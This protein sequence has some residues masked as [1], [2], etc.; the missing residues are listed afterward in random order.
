MDAA[1]IRKLADLEDQHW[2]Y[3]ERRAVL[4]RALDSLARAGTKPGR[5]LDIGAAGGGNTR[6]LRSRGW[7]AT[8]LEYGAEGAA[9]AHGRNIPVIRGD[10]VRLPLGDET[11]DLVV[12]YDVLEHIEDDKAASDEIARVLRPGGVALIAVPVDMALWSEHDV[13][14]GHVRRYDRERLLTVLTSAGLAIEDVRS[15]NVLLRPVAAWRRKKSTGSDLTELSPVVNLGLTAVIAAERYLPV[16][17]LP[18]VSV[19]VRARRPL[20]PGDQ[21]A[22][23]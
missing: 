14:V 19:L 3:R 1:E 12:A 23:G 18:G 11:M 2:W 15:W 21:P 10:A 9:V 6:V 16:G 4:A 20:R 13:A 22:R 7:N 5:A 17:R 8:A